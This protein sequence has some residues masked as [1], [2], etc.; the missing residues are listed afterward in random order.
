MLLPDKKEMRE[1][2]GTFFSRPPTSWDPELGYVWNKGWNRILR[3]A[4]GDI[5]ADQKYYYNNYWSEPQKL[6]HTYLS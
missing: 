5:V 4:H 2:K 3:V 1:I 6:A